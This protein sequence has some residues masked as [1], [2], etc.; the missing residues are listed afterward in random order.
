MITAPLAS[1]VCPWLPAELGRSPAAALRPS[2]VMLSEESPR[3]LCEVKGCSWLARCP[4]VPRL[5]AAVKVLHWDLL[6]FGTLMDLSL[7]SC[8]DRNVP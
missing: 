1:L 4:A 6:P 3:A 8:L 5:I 2:Q 7:V